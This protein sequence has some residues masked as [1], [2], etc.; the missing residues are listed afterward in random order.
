MPSVAIRHGPRGDFVWLVKSD[1]TAVVRNVVVGQAFGD[2]SLVERG[3]ARNER[4]V[5]EGYYRLRSGS[6]VIIEDAL[7]S[8]AEAN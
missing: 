1:Q 2:R 8:T 4:A 5:T 7:P 3:L 6:R